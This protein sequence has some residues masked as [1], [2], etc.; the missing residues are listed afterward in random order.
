M[1]ESCTTGT[2]KTV[3]YDDVGNIASKSDLAG[4]G[5]GNYAYP[6]PGSAH[7]HAVTAINGLVNGI[8]NPRFKYDLNGNLTC[9][10]TG[11]SCS[12][13][14]I[15]RQSDTYWSF[16]MARTV[17]EGTTSLTLT[18]DSEH[19]RIVQ[20]LSTGGT[21]ATTTYLNDPIGGAM[22]EKVVTGSTTTW[23]DYLM[24]DGL[25]YRGNT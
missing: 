16:D 13:S 20:A 15:A 4:G 2:A 24:A 25:I 14:G 17:T 9:E 7:P 8:V 19:A 11:T 22:G 23:N 3:A 18:Y 12:G 1:P 10:Y 6:A 5:S 21:P